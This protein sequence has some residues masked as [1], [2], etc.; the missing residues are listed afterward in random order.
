MHTKGGHEHRAKAARDGHNKEMGDD[1]E[2][3][4]E[5]YVHSYWRQTWSEAR[6]SCLPT[7][8]Q[9]AVGTPC[10]RRTLPGF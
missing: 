4:N 8:V 6:L 2:R 3:T 9:P 5:M 7:S 10:L 1:R